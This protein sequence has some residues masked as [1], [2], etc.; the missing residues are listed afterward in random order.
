MDRPD[1]GRIATSF[2]L[3]LTLLGCGANDGPPARDGDAA[4][5]EDSTLPEDSSL[6]GTPATPDDPAAQDDPTVPGTPLIPDRPADAG[7]GVG[8]VPD[9]SRLLLRTADGEQTVLATRAG[10]R[11]VS[12]A[13]RPG[14]TPAE[15]AVVALWETGGSYRLGWLRIVGGEAGALE[16][17]P[18]HHQPTRM[19]PAATLEGPHPTVA[20][21]PDGRSLGWIEWDAGGE[22]GLRTVG[23]DEG[24]GTGDPATD[25]ASFGID[26]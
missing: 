18:S 11:F 7:P 5:P 26:P 14:S 23:W 4:P 17:F 10:T 2:A 25:N 16:P 20:W 15:A 3:A 13:A 9:G 6:P 22:T 19:T 8:V 21:A 12:A 24:P 1:L